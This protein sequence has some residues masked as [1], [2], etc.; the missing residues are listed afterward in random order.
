MNLKFGALSFIFGSL[1]KIGDH[2]KPPA[3]ILDDGDGRS[4]SQ[5]CLLG[6]YSLTIISYLTPPTSIEFKSFYSQV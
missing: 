2:A 3:R 6:R 4:P 1:G 5:E